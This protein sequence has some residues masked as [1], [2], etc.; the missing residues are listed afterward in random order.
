MQRRPGNLLIVAAILLACAAPARAQN[1]ED[2]GTVF[3]LDPVALAL[4]D[5]VDGRDDL[6]STRGRF[7]YRFTNEENRRAFEAQ[8]TKYEIQLGGACGSMG[9]LSGKG[10]IDIWTTYEG[11]IYLFASEG[12]RTRFLRSPERLVDRPDPVPAADDESTARGKELLQRAAEAHGGSAGID[13]LGSYRQIREWQSTEGGT[14]YQ[15]KAVL[16][17]VLPD[18]MAHENWYDDWRVTMSEDGERAW[19]NYY[20]GR[21]EVMQE[22]SRL[23]LRRTLVQ[24]PLAILAQRE[25][26]AL[27]IT[28]VQDDPWSERLGENADIVAVSRDGVTTHL[29]ID[30]ESGLIVAAGYRNRGPGAYVGEFV[31][32]YSEFIDCDGFLLP[33][34]VDTTFDG[35]PYAT[36]TG[37]FTAIEVNASDH[38]AAVAFEP[39][40]AGE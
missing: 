38:Q 40:P 7:T 35:Q 9:P 22:A 19:F 25:D 39:K 30:R 14:T 6:T 2:T 15:R 37:T 33:Q 1:E 20:D 21:L 11:Q 17:L 36:E 18:S 24:H 16:T 12:C 26:P 27:L 4:G 10:S 31:V 32:R 13:R 5:E 3:P 8:P 23:A 34:R 29:A 28:A